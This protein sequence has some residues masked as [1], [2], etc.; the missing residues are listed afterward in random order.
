ML[1]YIHHP[2]VIRACM[3]ILFS[4]PKVT[5]RVPPTCTT[6]TSRTTFLARAEPPLLCNFEMP[7][8]TDT[9]EQSQSNIY[10]QSFREKQKNRKTEQL[11]S[12]TVTS[13]FVQFNCSTPGAAL[14]Y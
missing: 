14:L 7:N 3:F 10:Q 12:N 6:K 8:A 2:K 1:V 13:S 5:Q 4:V 11:P 9:I